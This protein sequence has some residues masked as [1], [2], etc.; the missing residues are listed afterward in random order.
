M[1]EPQPKRRPSEHEIQAALIV[2]TDRVPARVRSTVYTVVLTLGA[3]LTLG[4]DVLDTWLTD[5]A[6][7]R[8]ASALALLG[9]ALSA[10]Y[11]PTR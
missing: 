2:V 6:L 9:G 10:A 3:V 1:S 11:R 7:G 8:A 4:W 5:E